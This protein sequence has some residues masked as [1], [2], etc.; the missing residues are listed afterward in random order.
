MTARTNDIS[1]GGCFVDLLPPLPS[2]TQVRVRFTHGQSHL[3]TTGD[4][5]YSQSGSGMGIA[6]RPMEPGEQRNLDLCIEAFANLELAPVSSSTIE[7]P[8]A[9]AASEKLLK[10]LILLLVDRGV[11]QQEDGTA[12]F[13]EIVS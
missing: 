5:I 11:I 3:E 13:S 10:K 9:K 8:A 7:G 6:F 1:L 12:L 4:V 2:G